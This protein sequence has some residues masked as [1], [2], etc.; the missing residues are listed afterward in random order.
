MSDGTCFVVLDGK[1]AKWKRTLLIYDE[2]VYFPGAV[3]FGSDDLALMYAAHDGEGIL[4]WRKHVYLRAEFL[5]NEYPKYRDRIM[6][7]ASAVLKGRN[8]N[9][10]N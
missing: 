10:V 6:E 8:R 1:G 2:T 4:P 3:F 7:A 5:A 9:A